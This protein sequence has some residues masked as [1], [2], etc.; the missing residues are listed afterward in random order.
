MLLTLS[1]GNTNISFGI[2]DGARLQRQGGVSAEDV[3]SL[4]DRIGDTR[5]NQVALASVVPALTDRVVPMLATRYNTPVLVAGRDLPYGIDIQCDDPETVGAD[6]L[7]NAVGA[8]ARTLAVTVVADIGTAITVD[9]VSAHGTFCGGAIAPGPEAMLRSLREHTA[10]LPLAAFEPAAPEAG[11]QAFNTR[12][13]TRLH[14]GGTPVGRR[15][16]RSPS[17]VGHNTLDA[18]RSGVYWGTVGLVRNLIQVLLAEQTGPVRVLVTG[19]SGEWVTSEMN[20]DAEFVPT[21]TLEGLAA[22]AATATSG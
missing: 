18:I 11:W 4:P 21:L 3:Q 7:L 9:L 22:L 8:F 17:P 20:M 16:A 12:T 14:G 2:F 15:A 10:L 19:G 6:R 1:I 5:F 13:N